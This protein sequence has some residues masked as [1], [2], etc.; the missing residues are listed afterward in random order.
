MKRNIHIRRT[1]TVF[2]LCLILACS[3]ACSSEKPKESGEIENNALVNH[4]TQKE[5]DEARETAFM[6]LD[7]PWEAY[8]KSA[9]SSAFDELCQKII[10]NPGLGALVSGNPVFDAL[11]P[12]GYDGGSGSTV[13][14]HYDPAS[15]DLSAEELYFD[16]YEELKTMLRAA[17]DKDIAAGY[18]K[19][20]ADENYESLIRLYD[21]VIAGNTESIG[22]E[23]FDA[24]LEHYYNGG[25]DAETDHFYWQM[26]DAEVAAIKDH[27]REYHLYDEELD[28]SFVIHVTT[29]PGYDPTL[30]YP[31]FVMTDAV[32]RFN[33]VPSLYKAMAD[34]EA[35]PQ[36]LVTVGF[37]YDTDGWDNEVRA[38]ILCDHKKEFLDFLS[39]N[40]MPYLEERYP[41]D[42]GSSTLFG[43]SQGAVFTHYAAFHYDLYG[44][45]PFKKYIIGSPTFWTPYFTAVP[46]YEEYKNEYA[47][48]TRNDSY[49]RELIITAGEHED[50][51]YSE[52]YGENDS[53]TEGVAHLKER[54]DAYGITDYKV[55]MYDSH[56]Y[57]YVSGMLA[58]FIKGSL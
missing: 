11:P 56:H 14:R 35:A 3:T 43:H 57:Q 37:E 1:L 36:I 7:H 23:L 48:F 15:G 30:S 19:V 42:Y 45:R 8:D 54:L 34:K 24:Y 33:D 39:N 52:Y 41:F 38:N 40:M 26:N 31:A 13:F 10:F 2:L 53:T 22:Q 51:D 4:M 44:N 49:D 25:A 18:P 32:W 29:P 12:A 21:A 28:I 47:F 46:D 6:L 58:E 55:K 17:Y 20:P 50:E 9:D 5:L 16:D 27:I